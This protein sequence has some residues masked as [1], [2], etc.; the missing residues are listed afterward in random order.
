M[1][2]S[3][4]ACA[5]IC[6]HPP[7]PPASVLAA[8]YSTLAARGPR[9]LGSRNLKSQYGFWKILGQESY[10]SQSYSRGVSVLMV[11]VATLEFLDTAGLVLVEARLG[12]MIS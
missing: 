11:V 3:V 12:S 9:G 1:R 8:R 4:L 6:V 7:P 2:L 10:V 5:S